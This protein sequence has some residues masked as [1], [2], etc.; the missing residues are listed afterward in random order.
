MPCCVWW[1][2]VSHMIILLVSHIQALFDSI[3]RNFTDSQRFF[4]VLP[5]H[6]VHFWP[7]S[8]WG[9]M[10][11]DFWILVHFG[12]DM[13]NRRSGGQSIL[14]SLK[15]RNWSSLVRL[16]WGMTWICKVLQLLIYLQ[17]SIAHVECWRFWSV[18]ILGASSTGTHW[19]HSD[20]NSSSNTLKSSGGNE[21]APQRSCNKNPC[22]RNP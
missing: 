17:D 22:L 5:A 10:L 12:V 7:G 8:H 11:L 14:C 13:W 2:N 16:S 3:D 18:M 20:G 19:E 6:H 15:L 1:I 4:G 9:S 21:L